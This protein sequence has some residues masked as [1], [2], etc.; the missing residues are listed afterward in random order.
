[1]KLKNKTKIEVFVT[2]ATKLEIKNRAD[3][4]GTTIADIMKRALEQYL[5]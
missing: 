5:K 3:L 4:L 1:M 2:D